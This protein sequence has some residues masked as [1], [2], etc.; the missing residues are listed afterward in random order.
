MKR[1][2]F[3]IKQL[4]D[5]YFEGQTSLQEEQI[6]RD[7]FQRNDIDESL[8]E[9]KP[10]FDFFNEEG[11]LNSMEGDEIKIPDK[12]G[13]STARKIWF[14]RIS[15]SIAASAIL[16]FGIKLTFFNQKKDTSEQS[17]VYVDGKKFTDKNTIW[18]QTL[19]TLE[20][21]SE[22]EDDVIASQI[23]ILDS[24]NDF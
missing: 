3:N 6:L 15:M 24:F 2:K 19:N 12:I 10:M 18:F 5:L 16:F 1:D 20:A 8:M 14:N 4:L 11:I 13:Y 7:Y 23:D 17:I 9:Y 22:L 21:I